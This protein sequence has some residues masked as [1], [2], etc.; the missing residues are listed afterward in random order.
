[1]RHLLA[2]SAIQASS[3]AVAGQQRVGPLSV[4]L[5]CVLALVLLA[6]VAFLCSKQSSARASGA[7]AS[8]AGSSGAGASG[9]GARTALNVN[10]AK[11][12]V[13][14]K[15]AALTEGMKSTAN[16]SSTVAHTSGMLAL[17]T[18]ASA[19]DNPQLNPMTDTTDPSNCA[20]P[21]TA[22]PCMPMDTVAMF[23]YARHAL[24][25]HPRPLHR[26]PW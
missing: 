19:G 12:C 6:G 17:H 18:D 11:W 26:P 8:G 3:A 14:A 9:A 21:T 24:A 1:M 16:T 2:G 15:E 4:V 25:V 13:K 22:P 23:Q 5:A 20:P 7:G 10:T